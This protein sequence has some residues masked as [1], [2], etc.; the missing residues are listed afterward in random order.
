LFEYV[1][2]AFYIEEAQVRVAYFLLA[3]FGLEFPIPAPARLDIFHSGDVSLVHQET[4]HGFEFN[5][6]VYRLC[7]RCFTY[8]MLSCKLPEVLVELRLLL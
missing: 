2:A 7:S 4:G 1:V 3:F 8:C 5:E 6:L